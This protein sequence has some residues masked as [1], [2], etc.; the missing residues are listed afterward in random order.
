[1]PSI[2]P[3]YIYTIFASILVGAILICAVGMVTA[4][5]KV[6]AEKQQL[7]NV[8]QYVAAKS[9]ELISQSATSNV[10]STVNLSLPTTIGNQQYWISISNDTAKVWV[11]VGLGANAVSSEQRA[12]IPS[13]VSASGV[14]LSTSGAANLECYSDIS[15]VHLTIYGGT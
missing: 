6:T 8:A 3:S 10:N 11:E 12:Y 14:Y 7:S 15:G 5:V 2:I 1:M 4:N 9:L 13:E